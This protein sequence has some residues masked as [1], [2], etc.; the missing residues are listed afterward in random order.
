MKASTVTEVSLGDPTAESGA[1]IVGHG[2]KI[3]LKLKLY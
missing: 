3:K 2:S 1:R